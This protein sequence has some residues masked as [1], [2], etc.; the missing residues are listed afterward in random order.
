M[1]VILLQDVAKLGRRYAIV[2][3]PD[4]YGVNKLIPKGLAKAATPENV[5]AVMARSGAIAHSKEAAEAAFKELL[6]ALKDK[7]V[8]LSAEANAEGRF[9]QAL[10]PEAI[11]AA[12]TAVAGVKVTPHQIGIAE[13]IKAVGEHVVTLSLGT[14]HE[15]LTI[16][17]TARA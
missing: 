3:V 15:P 17:V 4:G 9:F 16:T 11:A 13:P 14:L 10:K 7:V 12:V 1:K 5:K 8:T 2:E 6:A